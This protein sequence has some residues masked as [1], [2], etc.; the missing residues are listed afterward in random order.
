VPTRRRPRSGKP[1]FGKGKRRV[2]KTNRKG[3]WFILAKAGFLEKSRFKE[4]PRPGKPVSILSRYQWT[5]IF[6]LGKIIRFHSNKHNYRLPPREAGIC[7]S[8]KT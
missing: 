1:I 4:L 5:K 2:C 6:K 7:G 3:S 8:G